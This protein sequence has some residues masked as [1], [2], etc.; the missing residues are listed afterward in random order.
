MRNPIRAVKFLSSKDSVC[1]GHSHI[2]WFLFKIMW[3][4]FSILKPLFIHGNSCWFRTLNI[5][6]GH[7]TFGDHETTQKLI[8]KGNPENWTRKVIQIKMC[9]SWKK[10]CNKLEK[11][12][13]TR[14]N[15]SSNSK[16]IC[17][18]TLN[19]KL[20]LQDIYSTK[21]YQLNIWKLTVPHFKYYHGVI[22]KHCCVCS[23]R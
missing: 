12:I 1:F 18:K 9:T 19:C 8:F 22:N 15:Q 14:K 13:G 16:R 17:N 2:R 3:V 5:A 11:E 6:F 21:F 23:K 10:T 20:L 7:M 4:N